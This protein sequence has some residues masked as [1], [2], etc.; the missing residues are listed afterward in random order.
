MTTGRSSSSR[1]ILNSLSDVTFST[2][3]LVCLDGVGILVFLTANDFSAVTLSPVGV[4]DWYWMAVV[5]V[6]EGLV[7]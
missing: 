3:I 6:N 7:S 4:S 1:N 2:M 5:E